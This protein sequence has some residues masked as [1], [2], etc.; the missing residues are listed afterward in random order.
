MDE[1]TYE[2]I[3]NVGK[4]LNLNG[5]LIVKW[6]NQ[7][8]KNAVFSSE[9]A[10]NIQ[11]NVYFETD[12]E[13]YFAYGGN[14]NID[15]MK[16]R[17]CE[18]VKFYPVV[19]EGYVLSFDKVI[20][21]YY[22][23][24]SQDNLSGYYSTSSQDNLSG[25]SNL[26]PFYQS[27][28]SYST[29]KHTGDNSDVVCGVLYILKPGTLKLLDDFEIDY[30]RN[31]VTLTLKNSKLL[32]DFNLNLQDYSQNFKIVVDAYFDLNPTK[33][34]HVVSQTYLNHL[35]KGLSEN[36]LPLIYIESVKNA[37]SLIKE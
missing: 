24:S 26:K 27:K 23:T 14:M 2:V 17:K 4:N 5:N 29:I 15:V 18:Y 10:E 7:S 19:L 31:K 35:V 34:K 21:H 9:G 28:Y 12:Y 25:Y 11:N 20:N 36:E 30:Y 6:K 37:L 1:N 3:K 8:S 13:F 32:N 33:R 22:S 16:K